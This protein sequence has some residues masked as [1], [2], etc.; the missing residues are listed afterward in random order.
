MSSE[1][2]DPSFRKNTIYRKFVSFLPSVLVTGWQKLNLAM[3]ISRPYDVR[4]G[5]SI[6]KKKMSEN[7]IFCIKARMVHF[8][9]FFKSFLPGLGH[10]VEPK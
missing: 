6:F 5:L 2:K 10:G 1:Y 3:H 8:L 7:F 4:E 9:Y